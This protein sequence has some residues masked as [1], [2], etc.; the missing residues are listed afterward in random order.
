MP[1]PQVHFAVG[2]GAAS[3]L[4]LPLLLLRRRWLIWLPL[5]MSVCGGLALVPDILARGR[6]LSPLAGV[7]QPGGRLRTHGPPANLFFL[8]T[9]LDRQEALYS[10]AI[11]DAAFHVVA[12]LYLAAACGYAACIHWGLPRMAETDEALARLRRSAAGY[13]PAASLLAVVPLLVAGVAAAWSVRSLRPADR[14]DAGQA[15]D[16]QAAWAQRV[17]RRLG[18]SV[19]PRLGVIHRVWDPNGQWLRGDLGALVPLPDGTPRPITGLADRAKANGCDFAVLLGRGDEDK[20]SGVTPAKAALDAAREKHRDMAILWG[21]TWEPPSANGRPRAWVLLPPQPR[22]IEIL[23]G[24]RGRFDRRTPET[25]VPPPGAALGWLDAQTRSAPAR[26]LVLADLRAGGTWDELLSWRETTV[27]VGLLGL[28]GSERVSAREARSG[29]APAVADVGG[30]WDEALDRGYCLWGAAAASG[31]Q[32]PA[33]HFGPGEFARTHVWSRGRTGDDVLAALR[34]GCFWAEEG[35]IVRE[36][37]FGVA[38]PVLER[39]A[40]MGEIARVAPGERVTVELALDIPPTDFAGRPNRLDEVEL[41]SNF[42]GVPAVVERF[43]DVRGDRRLEFTPPPAEDNNGGL[44]FYVRARGWR[45]QEGG[46]KLFFYTNPVRVLVRPGE[47]PSRPPGAAPVRVASKRPEAEP[48]PPKQAPAPPIAP[49]DTGARKQ[50]GDIG[51]P[52]SVQVLHI[53]TFQTP[54]AQH[55]RGAH[56]SYIGDRGPA[57]G[58]EELRVE[59]LKPFALGPATR[60]FFRCYA[61]DCSRLTLTLRSSLSTAAHQAVR[62]LPDKQWAEFDLSLTD[63]LLPTRAAAGPLRP[64]AEVRAVEWTSAKLSPLSRFYVT[65]FVVYEPTPSSRQEAAWRAATKLKDAL[66]AAA[67]RGAVPAAQRRAEAI[68][69]RLEAWEKRLD[70][71]AGALASADLE[72]AQRDLATLADESRRVQW[73]AAAARVFGI[74]DPGFAVSV[75]PPGQRVSA[76]N[77]AFAPSAQLTGSCELAAAAGEAESFQVV[78]IALWDRLAAVDVAA[79]DL[80]PVRGTH[81]AANVSPQPPLPASAVTVAL[82]DEVQVRPRAEL[83]PEEAGWIPDPLLPP[84]PFDVEPGAPRSV[85]VTISVPP[86]LLPGDYQGTVTVRPKGLEAVRVGVRLHRWDFAL[87]E[88]RLPVVGPLDERAIRARYGYDKGIPQPCRRR[89]YDLLLRHGVAPIPFLGGDEAADLDEL[90]FCL[91]RGAGLVV[92]HEAA[93][94]V[95]Q[96]RDANVLRA[97]HLAKKMADAGWGRRG[98]LVLPFVPAGDR[99]GARLTDFGRGLAREHPALLLVAG[100]DGEPPGDLVTNYWRR[101]LGTD[102]PRRPHDDDVEVRL[103]RTARREAWEL[104]AAIPGSGLPNLALT[105]R[106]S[107]ARLLPWLAWQH[108]VRALFLRNVARWGE[109]DLGDSALI[110]PGAQ[111]SPCGSLRLVALRDGVDDYELLRRL[112]DGARLLRE[113]A[114]ERHGPLLAAAERLLAE[115]P[116]GI[117]TFQRPCR[118]PQVLASLRMRLARELERVEAAWWAEVDAAPDLPAPP[119]EITAKP[120]NGLIVLSWAKSADGKVSGYHLYRSCDP[121]TGFVRLNATPIEGLNYTDRSVRGDLLYHYFVRACRDE[122]TEGPRSRVASASPRP[123]PKVVWL[124][125]APLIAAAAGPCRV[126][127]RLEG[128]GTGGLLPQVRP[129]IDYALGDAPLDGFEEMARQED[130]SWTFD[131]PEPV[132]RGHAGKTLRVQVRLV[133]RQN[134]VVAPPVEREEPIGGAPR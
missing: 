53:E 93:E 112:W 88:R 121:K 132:W 125:M 75:A 83:A 35:G 92:L 126:A 59:W 129:Q 91:E 80:L 64:P 44:G 14:S 57:M 4:G 95:P 89:L 49:S 120:G 117:G 118:D 42:S 9:W 69:T 16:E 96:A 34:G 26:P 78:V 38:A 33:K 6:D 62:E 77:P 116:G 67:D 11:G 87:L 23:A 5:V 1:M 43:R 40:R 100:G 103:S 71:K 55:W 47:A 97:G 111:G 74:P 110:Y 104:V 70:P 99:E 124:P 29:W 36:L 32:D 79:S 72:A 113:R 127:V 109:A 119:A 105:S 51:L 50:L 10:Q 128:P 28:T 2:M 45:K 3:L 13:R 12:F 82:V 48:T 61:A 130:G 123:A 106:L 60:L 25:A 98:A 101:P 108:G 134:D 54:P 37:D 81:S 30:V 66:L 131:I 76:R 27:V 7:A 73:Q 122:A 86:E 15:Q 24:F 65:D 63:D 19:G 58:D 133:D 21:A 85:L 114:A 115:V 46:S 102:P 31:S 17:S 84:R 94:P 68:C 39:P 52:G 22:E 56:V 41:I 18:V 20:L 8:H 107:D 90:R